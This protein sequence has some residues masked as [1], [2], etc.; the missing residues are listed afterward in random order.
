MIEY[1][2]FNEEDKTII[3][4]DFTSAAKSTWQLT[5]HCVVK[6]S[7]IT[8][9]TVFLSWAHGYSNNKP[10]LFET[11]I[12]GGDHDEYQAR[13]CTYEEALLQ[14]KKAKFIASSLR[15]KLKKL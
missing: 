6:D 13:C 15:E 10:L 2:E 3:K 14:H 11:M 9:S 7:P 8:V 1:Y 4:G 5:Y 12:F